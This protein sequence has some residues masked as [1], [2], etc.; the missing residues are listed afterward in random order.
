MQSIEPNAS[1]ALHVPTVWFKD[2]YW[3]K[4]FFKV[5][6]WA[7][8]KRIILTSNLNFA[9]LETALAALYVQSFKVISSFEIFEN[10]KSYTFR[11]S[12]KKSKIPHNMVKYWIWFSSHMCFL[13]LM[14]IS[15]FSG[16]FD[17]KFLTDSLED[18]YHLVGS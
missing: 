3:L 9:V 8:S 10:K 12:S 1:F 17:L 4:A 7:V 5:L 13:S 18:A 6:K 11:F 15:L 16:Q 2:H 14:L